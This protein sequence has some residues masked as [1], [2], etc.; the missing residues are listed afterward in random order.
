MELPIRLIA[1]LPKELAESLEQVRTPM[2]G[3]TQAIQAKTDVIIVLDDD[4]TGSQT[5]HGVSVLTDWDLK[6]I[7]AE[8]ERGSSLF[9][10]LTNSRSLTENKA[11][12]LAYTIGQNIKKAQQ[13]TGKQCMLISRS[14]STLR[15]HYP[16]E[17][18]ALLEGLG[19]AKSLTIIIPAFFEGGRYTIEDVHY[20]R[21]AERLIPAAQTAY[22]RDHYFGFEHSQL[23]AWIEEKTAAKVVS[24]E[25]VSFSIEE[26]RTANEEKL[27]AKLDQCRSG[28][29]VIVNALCYQ[30]LQKFA[31][32]LFRSQQAVI[33]R[34]AASFV[35]AL[36][37]QAPKPWLGQEILAEAHKKQ[38]GLVVVGSYVPK[39]TQQ[40][41]HLRASITAQFIEIEVPKLL[42]E[43]DIVP[44]VNQLS[45]E[46]DDH[47][48]AGQ[49]VV[50]YTSRDFIAKDEQD[51]GLDL[52][53]KIST[54]ISQI[55]G[56]LSRPPRYLISKGG[57][58][59]SDIA[60]KSLQIKAAKV[61][62]QILPGVPVWQAGPESLF[63]D[64][65]LII[66]PGNV[67]Q[68][69]SLSL[70]MQKLK[71]RP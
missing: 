24:E 50:L 60:T 30:D 70:V 62:G 14:D 1:D 6:S 11:K 26:L 49:D 48:Q 19:D 16:A 65:P 53:A 18:D 27:I 55:V 64:L 3:L 33:C 68:T 35:A 32:A 51:E 29:V 7:I 43:A 17:V 9:F 56:Q 38:G 39:T 57:I 10:I 36:Q 59:S 37:N 71:T 12:D 52:G 58:T 8:L 63:P 54:F 66:F 46:I 4:P 45:Q 41:A 67:G 20:V 42:A 13:I 61:M 23:A 31:L 44:K 2:S 69:D 28:Q 15:G 40:L 25:V 47:L 34:T 5:V 22:G 21:E